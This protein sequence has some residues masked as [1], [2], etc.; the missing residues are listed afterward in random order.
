MVN[1]VSFPDFCLNI[2]ANATLKTRLDG[3]GRE[4]E[5]NEK[6]KIKKQLAYENVNVSKNMSKMS[7][8]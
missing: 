2:V 7:T 3:T 1:A 5:N 8:L 6:I 4:F